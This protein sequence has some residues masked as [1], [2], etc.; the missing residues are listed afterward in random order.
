MAK[1]IYDLGNN[2]GYIYVTRADSANIVYSIRNTPEG[3][4]QAKSIADS[5]RSV[6]QNLV[7]V[8]SIKIDTVTGIGTISA[9]NIQEVHAR[10]PKTEIVLSDKLQMKINE[11]VADIT[12]KMT[13][14]LNLSTKQTKKVGAIKLCE[15]TS[16]E[17]ERANTSKSQLEIKNEIILL[18]NESDKK[19][20]KVLK[21]D[22]D[23]IY[24][25][26]KDDYKYN[27]GLME[28][29]KDF[30]KDTKENIKEKLGGN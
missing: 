17:K 20:H 28:K 29:M 27:P 7:A 24:E 14:D 22:Q 9:I 8:G 3:S 1:G 10:K 30:Y 2:R 23:V 21:K 6:G 4:F 5:S 16:I 19:I 13:K 18:N 11:K 15:A 12:K 25:A 26:K